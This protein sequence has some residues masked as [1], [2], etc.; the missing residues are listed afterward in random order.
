LSSK[1]DIQIFNLWFDIMAAAPTSSSSSTTT[2]STGSSSVSPWMAKQPQS[3]FI[4]PLKF[5]NSLPDIPFDPKLLEYPFDP[6]RFV[7]YQPTSLEKNFKFKIFSEPDLGIT[8]DLIDPT[9]YK[10]DPS[11]I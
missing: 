7:R 9:A 10:L 8:I 6:D 4:C 2:K 3:K 1:T 11:L 5:R